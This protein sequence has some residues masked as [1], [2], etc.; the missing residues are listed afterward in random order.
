MHH[1]ASQGATYPA[2]PFFAGLI[3]ALGSPWLLTVRKGHLM[4]SFGDR[5]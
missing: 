2:P 4:A 5:A 3:D 1:D